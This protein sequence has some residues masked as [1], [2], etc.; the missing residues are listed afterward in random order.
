MHAWNTPPIRHLTENDNRHS[1]YAYEYS[2]ELVHQ[3]LATLTRILEDTFETKMTGYR[4]GR[5][6]FDGAS[7]RALIDLG[8]L[9]DCS[10]TP[11]V[12]WKAHPG[13]PTGNGGPDF[14]GCPDKPYF[15][16]LDDIRRPG[17]SPLLELPVTIV[18]TSPPVVDRVRFSLPRRHLL[19]K[20]LNRTFP[21]LTWLLPDGRNGRRMLRVLDIA[22]KQGR[23]YV[24]FIIHSS[25]LMPGVNFSFKTPASIERLYRDLRALFARAAQSFRPATLSGFAREIAS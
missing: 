7:A 10:V 14:T 24:E 9:V 1:T 8:Y 17:D 20:V 11:G 19:R 25:E 13:L 2:P 3:K 5:F 16:D 22:L 18:P 12:S 4:A 21:P 23:P 15:V 6:G